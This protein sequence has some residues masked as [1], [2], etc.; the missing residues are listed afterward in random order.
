LL[1]ATAPERNASVLCI[2]MVE[3]VTAVENLEAICATPGVDA[4]YVGPSDLGLSHGLAPG[5]ELD[6][7]I[8]GIAAT[9]GRAGV[10]AGLHTRSGAAARAAV[11]LGFSFATISSDRDLLARAARTELSEALGREPERRAVAEAD[12][13]R[14]AA[15]LS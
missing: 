3:T 12:L 9:C 6:A 1:G 7:V 14:A 15:Y 10:P 2:V 11:D 5:P 13:L 8:A 4:V